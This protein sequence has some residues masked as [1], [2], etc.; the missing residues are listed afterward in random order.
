MIT[1]AEF[2][3]QSEARGYKPRVDPFRPELF[4]I[5]SK[6]RIKVEINVKANSFVAGYNISPERRLRLKEVLTSSGLFQMKFPGR[7]L[8]YAENEGLEKFWD[9]VAIVEGVD[10]S[11]I[12]RE[13]APVIQPIVGNAASMVSLEEF[14][15][16][17]QARGYSGGMQSGRPELFVAKTKNGVKV[18]INTR[19][20][21]YIAGYNLDEEE[22]LALRT[23]LLRQQEMGVFELKHPERKLVYAKYEGMDKFWEWAN[24][25]ENIDTIVRSTKGMSTK[26][27]TKQQAEERIFEKIA[28]T[29]QFAIRLEHQNLLDTSRILLEADKLDDLIRVGKSANAPDDR[30]YREHVVPCV[31]I[32]NEV[33]RILLDA[34]VRE[35]EVPD[36]VIHEIAKLIESNLAIVHI[37]KEEQELL[38]ITLGLRTSMPKNWKFGDNIFARLEAAELEWEAYDEES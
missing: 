35:K 19:A 3:A 16:Q 9:W 36:E 7:S 5:N 38:D 29:Y 24:I 14:V 23:E 6:N 2:R 15:S 32:H 27:F 12:P 20:R 22:R 21:T 4:I 17:C 8:A 11:N 31:L 28:R 13:L 25:I 33:I 37:S 1:F 18:E 34:G 26:V 30:P 10:F